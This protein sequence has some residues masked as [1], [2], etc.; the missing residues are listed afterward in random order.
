MNRSLRWS[1][2]PLTLLFVLA[3]CNNTPGASS[4]PSAGASG[5]QPA[6][7]PSAACAVLEGGCIE[8]PAG[9]PLQIATALSITGDTSSLGLD[10]Q[11]GAQVAQ[12]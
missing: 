9:E 5:S 4:S 6:Q 1:A 10:S 2:V 7:D 12:E 3:A 8:V 11:F